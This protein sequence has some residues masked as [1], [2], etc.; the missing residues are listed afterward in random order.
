MEQENCVHTEH[1][2]VIHGC[3]YCDSHCPVE[4][5]KK[6]QSYMCEMCE[7]LEEDYKHLQEY[8]DHITAGYNTLV[9]LGFV[10]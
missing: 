8:V 6:K 3:K 10:K 5:G 2:C 9:A 7:S 1:C 4:L